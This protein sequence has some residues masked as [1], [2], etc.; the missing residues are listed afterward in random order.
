MKNFVLS[1]NA[2][3][4]RSETH[5][6]STTFDTSYYY[7]PE[8]PGIPFPKF[9][10]RLIESKQKLEGQPEFYGNVSL[11]YDIGGFSA[12]ISV[13]HQAEFNSTFSASGRSDQ[14][15]NRYTR[16]DLALKQRVSDYLSILLSINNLTG[17]EERASIVNRVNNYTLLNTSERYGLTADLG[18]KL[19]L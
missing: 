15:A 11:G 1:Y 10:T 14:V 7:L 13:F 8:F 17:V 16:V 3:L 5:L 6:Y 9:T 2:S 19:E 4:L 18:I 12:R